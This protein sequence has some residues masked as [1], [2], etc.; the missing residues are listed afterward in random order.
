MSPLIKLV[1]AG[2]KLLDGNGPIPAPL[3]ARRRSTAPYQPC[4]GIGRALG[5][6][7]AKGRQ[8][9]VKM[10]GGDLT[11]NLMTTLVSGSQPGAPA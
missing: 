10:H 1:F 6:L 11:F 9:I 3:T 8:G 4:Q 5:F 7:S 2:S